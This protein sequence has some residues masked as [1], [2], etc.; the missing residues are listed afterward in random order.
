M[1]DDL[2]LIIFRG[3]NLSQYATLTP[4]LSE[5]IPFFISKSITIK[6]SFYNGY[7]VSDTDTELKNIPGTK[8]RKHSV[9]RWWQECGLDKFDEAVMALAT[10]KCSQAKRM[11]QY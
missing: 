6:D 3:E 2:A 4:S 11:I 7:P 10:L 9:R 8:A 1:I 5:T